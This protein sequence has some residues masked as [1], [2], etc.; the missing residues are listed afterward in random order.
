MADGIKKQR[1]RLRCSPT[2]LQ[3]D[4]V[5]IET[6][7]TGCVPGVTQLLTVPYQDLHFFVRNYQEITKIPSLSNQHQVG[8]DTDRE[9]KPIA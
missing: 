6:P 5:T 1:N 9:K 8:Q 4:T 2:L 3:I 7:I